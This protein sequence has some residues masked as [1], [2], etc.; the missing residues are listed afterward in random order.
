MQHINTTMEQ[1]ASEQVNAHETPR[2]TRCEWRVTQE[3]T[4]TPLHK[5][6]EHKKR[7]QHLFYSFQN[8]PTSIE[9][10][11]TDT[12]HINGENSTRRTRREMQQATQP[13]RARKRSG[14][15]ANIPAHSHSMTPIPRGFAPLCTRARDRHSLTQGPALA[16]ALLTP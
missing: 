8:V 2:L 4:Q 15:P 3:S 14:A 5:H 11:S 16:I 7:C 13:A 6:N 1:T 9:S 12:G 10:T